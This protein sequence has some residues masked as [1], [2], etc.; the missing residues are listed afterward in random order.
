[1]D[2]EFT[3]SGTPLNVEQ[4]VQLERQLG[5]SLP[6]DYRSFLLTVN[7]GVPSKSCFFDQHVEDV[8]WVDYFCVIDA[9]L[10]I[11]TCNSAPFS[12]AMARFLGWNSAADTIPIGR[13]CAD[14]PLL[15]FLHGG[16][17]GRVAIKILF[18]AYSKSPEELYCEPEAGIHVVTNS[19]NEFVS[20][21]RGDSG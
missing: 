5:V 13:V 20:S 11:T 6:T 18:E 21:L 7:G 17:R 10:A 1:M 19:F 2:Q 3:F 4:I 14:N 8:L 12:L 16:N 15:L 9:N